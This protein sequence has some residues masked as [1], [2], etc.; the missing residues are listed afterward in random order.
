MA[1]EDLLQDSMSLAMRIFEEQKLFTL[2][3]P[4]AYVA[5]ETTLQESI[6]DDALQDVVPFVRPMRNAQFGFAALSTQVLASFLPAYQRILGTPEV[7]APSIL[8]RIYEHMQS[9]SLTVASRQFTFGSPSAGGSNVGNGTLTRLTKD[10]YD[11]DIENGSA[12]GK[13]FELV[14]DEHSGSGVRWRE[15]FEYRGDA[16]E[17][18]EFPMRGQGGRAQLRC[19]SIQDTQR[20][21]VN[22][23]FESYDAT[24]GFTGWTI[25]NLVANTTQDTTNYYKD[26]KPSTTTPA[27]LIF[28]ASDLIYQTFSAQSIRWNPFVPMYAQIAW[29]RRGSATGNLKLKIGGIT[30]T[31][32][33]STGTNDEW[34]ILRW[35]LA[36]PDQTAWFRSWNTS[37]A[38]VSIEAESLATGTLVVDDLII[39]PYTQLDGTWYVMNGG[40]ANSA[41][42]AAAA[43]PFLR[44]DIFTFTDSETGAIVQEWMARAFGVYLPHTT[45]TATWLD[46]T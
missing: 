21:V 33:I 43:V 5:M 38:R 28:G 24:N 45:G 1:A 29:M 46:P 13:T 18:N 10:R 14:D 7:D 22:P 30:A 9:N 32:D 27:A 8:Y 35:P 31:V 41:T 37:D 2:T 15:T 16:L 25:T 11:H 3:N 42:V 12:E 40:P 17:R 26:V 19:L 44:D 23:G 6:P 34:N 36:T 4:V 39:A 20:L